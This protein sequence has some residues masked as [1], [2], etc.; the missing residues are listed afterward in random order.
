MLQGVACCLATNTQFR[1]DG[2][3]VAKQ[4]KNS[5]FFLVVNQTETVEF[6]LDIIKYSRENR[7]SWVQG[8]D[9][10]VDVYQRLKPSASH[11]TIVC[12]HCQCVHSKN[13]T[14]CYTTPSPSWL[15][16]LIT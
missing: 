11:C 2:Q 7:V 4:Q 5:V 6:Q 15:L 8:S 3:W 14:N 9:H 16:F 12:F 13:L 10:V 1:M